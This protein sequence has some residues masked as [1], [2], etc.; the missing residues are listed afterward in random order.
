M[1][2]WSGLGQTHSKNRLICLHV[3]NHRIQIAPF[4]TISSS[5]CN[6]SGCRKKYCASW[7][8]L[9]TKLIVCHLPVFKRLV[10]RL[11]H[12]SR[13]QF[14]ELTTCTFLKA[15]HRRWNES[16]CVEPL[17]DSMRHLSRVQFAELKS[18]KTYTLLKAESRRWNESKCVEQSLATC[19]FIL[20]SL[21]LLCQVATVVILVQ[22]PR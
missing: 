16:T 13:V 6:S 15:G 4:H 19:I 9:G 12:L 10:S 2:C 5:C 18:F 3:L 21:S 11:T 20:A 7:D 14:A 8:V 17:Q 22:R 1:G